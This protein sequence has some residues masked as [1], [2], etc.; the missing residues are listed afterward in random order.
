MAESINQIRGFSV[1]HLKICSIRK[2]IN[3][4]LIL[5]R[6]SKYDVFTIS[7][8]WLHSQLESSLYSIEGYNLL[9]QDR[10]YDDGDPVTIK[11]RG[12]GLLAYV[13][14]KPNL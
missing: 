13:A 14:D 7:E 12:G 8:S 1:A 4:V 6:D 11:K 10:N 5:L 9:R 3:E 2:K